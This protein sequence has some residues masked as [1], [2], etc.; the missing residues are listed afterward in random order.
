MFTEDDRL[1]QYTQ[2]WNPNL[3]N[4]SMLGQSPL[5]QVGLP[6]ISSMGQQFGFGD[7]GNALG[8]LLP[9][10]TPSM[11]LGAVGKIG[12]SLL[13]GLGGKLAGTALGKAAMANPVGAVLGGIQLVAGIGKKTEAAKRESAAMGRQI[14]HSKEAIT[15]SKELMETTKEVAEEDRDLGFLHAGMKDERSL[16]ALYRKGRQARAS[17]G[18]LVSGE[19]EADLADAEG[20]ILEGGML[21]QDNIV[22]HKTKTDAMAEAQHEAFEDKARKQIAELEKARSNL[23]TK[24]YQNIV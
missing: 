7:L 5:S 14:D 23:K 3:R 2:P 15:D 18:G 12:G 21:T 10:G 16:D 6:D 4:T 22:R 24:W 13:K 8:S 11:G 1:Q 19:I 20:D 17:T 9:G